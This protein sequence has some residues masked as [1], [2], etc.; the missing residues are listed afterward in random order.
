MSFTQ[1]NA[2]D[3]HGVSKG[4]VLATTVEGKHCRSCQKTWSSVTQW[5]SFKCRRLWGVPFMTSLKINLCTAVTTQNTTGYNWITRTKCDYTSAHCIFNWSTSVTG[6]TQNTVGFSQ[7]VTAKVKCKLHSYYVYI[8]LHLKIQSVPHKQH[9]TSIRKTS[10]RML[11]NRCLRMIRSTHVHRL[12]KTRS[13][14]YW[15]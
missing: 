4:P 14:E 5:P 6:H 10:W 13:F 7:R 12:D 11:C 15:T 9:S 8:I 2:V 1:E 3:L